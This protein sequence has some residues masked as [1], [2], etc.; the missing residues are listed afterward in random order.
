MRGVN[1]SA[2]R[3][4]A[5][6]RYRNRLMKASAV[7]ATARQPL[8]IVGA[9]PRFGISTISVTP[10]LRF[11]REKLALAIDHGTTWSRSPD[12]I[13]SGPRAG[14]LVSTFACVHG[15]RLAVAAWKMGAPDAG[16]A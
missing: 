11:W 7:S 4:N 3:T 14:F 2:R 13:S 10:A 16:T 1:V 6:T 9:W 15:L 5:R 12:M 8:W